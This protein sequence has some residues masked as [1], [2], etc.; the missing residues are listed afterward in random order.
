MINFEP[1][2]TNLAYPSDFSARWVK[3]GLTLLSNGDGYQIQET[4]T[5]GWHECYLPVA[6][7]NESYS[8]SFDVKAGTATKARVWF[9][10]GGAGYYIDI[11]LTL[12]TFV[13]GAFNNST[14]SLIK[15]FLTELEN[16]WFNVGITGK[17]NLVSGYIDISIMNDL[18]AVQ[19]IGTGRTMFIRKPQFEKGTYPSAFIITT[20]NSSTRPTA[21]TVSSFTQSLQM[22]F[23]FSAK[24]PKNNP[25]D[26]AVL[27]H[28]DNNLNTD[29]YNDIEMFQDSVG[30]LFLRVTWHLTNHYEIN[31][32]IYPSNEILCVAFNFSDNFLTASLN[33]GICKTAIILNTANDYNTIRLG[34]NITSDRE[35][36]APIGLSDFYATAKTKTELRQLAFNNSL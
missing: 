7:T 10:N 29:L 23:V 16:G 17:L 19:Y 34:S 36:G 1:T 3:N 12:K 11:D 32:G 26:Y 22:S 14:A 15:G 6:C 20:T 25:V 24:T 33:G 8:A 4:L 27:F 31:F 28:I 9:V 13:I 2:R 5:N 18:G 21:S 30:Q 35:W